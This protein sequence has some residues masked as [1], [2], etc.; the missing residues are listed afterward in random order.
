MQ[1]TLNTYPNL[2]IKA[3]SVHDVTFS[4]TTSDGTELP[5]VSGIRLE[6]GEVLRCKQVIICTGT[7]LAGEIHIG[8]HSPIHLLCGSFVQ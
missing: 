6:T 8:K 1:A 3:G 7:F 5:L 4:E 2:S